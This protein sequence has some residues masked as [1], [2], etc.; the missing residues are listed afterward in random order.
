MFPLSLGI[1]AAAGAFLY[2][3]LLAP[4]PPGTTV[5]NPAFS[6]LMLVAGGVGL[7]GGCAE[8]GRRLFP[9]RP[10]PLPVAPPPPPAPVAARPTPAWLDALLRWLLWLAGA[11]LKM[12]L[13]SLF[14]VG[15]GVWEL[16]KQEREA[17]RWQ[18]TE[19]VMVEARVVSRYLRTDPPRPPLVPRL[20]YRYQ[21]A[22]EP[23]ESTQVTPGDPLVFA[24][25]EEAEAFLARHRVGEPITVFY[26]PEAPAQATLALSRDGGCWLLFGFGVPSLLLTA[27]LSWKRRGKPEPGFDVPVTI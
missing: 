23:F 17:W 27:Y 7:Y 5:V 12:W 2:H 11:E 6:V 22:G 21:I 18:R 10:T 14:L 1:L 15:W 4:N 19:G 25:A 26:L 8:V 13:L 3:A 16:Y 24:T 20:R 9:S